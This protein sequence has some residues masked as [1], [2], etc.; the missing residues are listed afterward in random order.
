MNAVFDT[1]RGN[2]FFSDLSDAD[3]RTFADAGNTVEYEPRDLLLRYQQP[4][5]TFWVLA[6]G[7]VTLLNHVPGSRVRPIETIAAPDVVGW[8]WLVPPYRWHFDVKAQTYVQA[9][10]MNAE[11]LRQ[12]IAQNASLASRIYPHFMQ[13]L[14]DRLQASRLQGMD[15][16]ANTGSTLR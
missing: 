9:I 8:S 12:Q 10:A 16:Y 3:V 5:D 11:T 13:I 2:A 14:V 15:I 1:L 6:E 7:K 4:A